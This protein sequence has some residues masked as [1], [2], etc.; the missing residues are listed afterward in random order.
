MC[1][2]Y[3]RFLPHCTLL[4]VYMHICYEQKGTDTRLY[5]AQQCKVTY[6]SFHAEENKDINL[7]NMEFTYFSL[8]L[9][10]SHWSPHSRQLNMEFRT[11]SSVLFQRLKSWP[12]SSLSLTAFWHSLWIQLAGT[13]YF[14]YGPLSN[15]CAFLLFFFYTWTIFWPNQAIIL[16]PFII[17]SSNQWMLLCPYLALV[18]TNGEN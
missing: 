9:S 17:H 10:H 8:F 11:N 3:F 15:F 16:I 13:P 1:H 14:S 7:L 18:L 6:R 2:I 4:S 12:S 5:F